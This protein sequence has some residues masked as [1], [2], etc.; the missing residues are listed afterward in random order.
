MTNGDRLRKLRQ[1]KNLTLEELG[2]KLGVSHATIYKYEKGEIANMK[3]STI[4]KL[5]EIFGVSPVYIMGL[6]IDNPSIRM[7]DKVRSVP[8]LGTICAG[9][10]IW[11]EENY[12]GRFVLDPDIKGVDFV[13]KVDGESMTG[14][15]IHNGDI[16]FMKSTNYVENGKIAAVLLDN[17][18]VMLK[19]L[20]IK[21][22]HAVLTPS[23]PAFEPIVTTDFMILGELVG[24]YHEV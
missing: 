2:E 8:I 10:G 6:D 1:D 17:N 9:D 13:L 14:D 22:G 19:R 3:Q 18:E 16:A 15:N 11:C 21:S 24:V 20:N 5:A 23:N 7:V 4:K 12:E